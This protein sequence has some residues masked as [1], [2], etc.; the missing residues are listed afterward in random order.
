[1][2]GNPQVADQFLFPGLHQGLQSATL[3]EGGV[4]VGPAAD[5]MELPEVEVV[6]L[7]ALEAAL[8][9]S[10]RAIAGPVIGLAGQEDFLPAPLQGLAVIVLAR[11]IERSRVAVIDPQV[12]GA[13]D[14]GHRHL[15]GHPAGMLEG[16]LPPQREDR[17]RIAGA[18]EPALGDFLVGRLC[19][20]RLP[21]AAQKT[22]SKARGSGEAGAQKRSP[23][24]FLG[25]GVP[26][27]SKPPYPCRGYYK[28]CREVSIPSSARRNSLTPS[29]PLRV[30]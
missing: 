19:A 2:S 7:Q 20:Q 6:G 21:G 16:G 23:V 1:M 29:L 5:V 4:Q 14:D 15:A 13:V 22:Q 30:S 12:Q 28:E 18:A 8:E 10:Q 17:R 24:D 9:Q 3:G 26:P 11:T 25:H 27:E